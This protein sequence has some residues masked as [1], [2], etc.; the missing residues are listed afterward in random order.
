VRA[1][2]TNFEQELDHI[3]EGGRWRALRALPAA[4]GK[5]AYEGRTCLNFASNDYLNLANDPRVK[6][7]ACQAVEKYGCSATASRLI[8]G[9]LDIHEELEQKL[10]DLTGAESA[11][12]FPSG[13]QAN[14]GVLTT[15]ANRHDIIYADRNNHASIIDGALLSRAELQRYRHNDMDH[16]EALLKVGGKYRRRVIV[17][18]AVFSM[19]GDLADVVDLIDLAHHYDAILVID[20]A[21]AIGIFGEGGGICKHLAIQPH[22]IVGTLSKALGS[23]GGFVATSTQIRDLLINEARSFI[24]TTGLAPACAGAAIMAINIMQEHPAL[25]QDLLSTARRFHQK[26]MQSEITLS[27]VE[28]QIIPVIIGDNDKTTGIAKRL[29]DADIL[30]GA[31]RPPTVPKDTARLRISITRAHDEADLDILIQALAKAC[32]SVGRPAT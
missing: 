18:D 10:A 3:K 27:D 8:S 19:D 22:V 20:E 9:H 32:S 24:F 26:L 2:L 31:I 13:F 16:L 15:L 5:F 6:G 11:L 1:A 4:G 12:V 14:L 23:G 28:S 21:H 7:A 17:S 29:S 25:G 30:V